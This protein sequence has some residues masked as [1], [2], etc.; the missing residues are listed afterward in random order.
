M[1]TQTSYNRKTISARLIPSSEAWVR[2]K[3]G[4]IRLNPNYDFIGKLDIRM[5]NVLIS[6]SDSKRPTYRLDT[7]N[8]CNKAK[9]Q[10]VEHFFDENGKRTR[11]TV[12][13]FGKPKKISKQRSEK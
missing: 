6:P 13:Y 7:A 4:G 3:K 12:A 10:M 9:E 1:S 2:T 5:P 11:K 8:L